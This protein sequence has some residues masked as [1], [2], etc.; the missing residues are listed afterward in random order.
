MYL[1]LRADLYLLCYYETLRS[2]WDSE[3]VYHV[4][5]RGVA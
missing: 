2:S 4:H 1:L 5:G 3:R